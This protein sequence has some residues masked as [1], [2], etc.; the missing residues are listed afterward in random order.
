[1]YQ[2]LMFPLVYSPVFELRILDVS[3]LN[4]LLTCM[5]RFPELLRHCNI[6]S[7]YAALFS[8]TSR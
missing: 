6:T 7:D 8:N 3:K 2:C 5:L 1:M 4:V